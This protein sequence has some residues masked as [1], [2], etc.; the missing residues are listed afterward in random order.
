M[1][2]PGNA[3]SHTLVGDDCKEM[4]CYTTAA[5]KTVLGC[6]FGDTDPIVDENGDSLGSCPDSMCASQIEVSCREGSSFLFSRRL[7]G[8][9]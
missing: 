4:A 8:R 2:S 5:T 6:P 9:G 3:I 1:N 7:S